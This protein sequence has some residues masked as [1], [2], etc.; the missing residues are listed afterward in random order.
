MRAIGISINRWQPANVLKAL[1]TGLIDSV[2][3]VYNVFDQAPE[4]ELF[5]EC[6]RRNIAV[7]AR[8]PF[9]EGSLTGTL[10]ANTTWPDGDFRNIYFQPDNLAQTIER[11]DRLRPV[12]P[13]G[14]AMPELAL[15]FIL[16]NRGRRHRDPRHAQA[17]ARGR[18]PRRERRPA[19][20]RRPHEH[21]APAT[22]GSLDRHSLGRLSVVGL[23]T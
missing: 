16:Q 10:T 7:I 17:D 6:R 1:A 22:V 8:V 15:R 13:H 9:D 21:T 4:D 19:A 2:Q 11:I 23:S 14:M 18:Q 5:V 20:T 3:V 12:V